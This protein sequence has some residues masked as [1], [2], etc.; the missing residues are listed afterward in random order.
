MHAQK[1]D[2]KQKD[3]TTGLEVSNV[4]RSIDWYRPGEARTVD[5]GG[6]RIT[7]VLVERRG[8]RARIAITAPAGALF[9]ASDCSSAVRER[10][11]SRR[12]KQS[13]Y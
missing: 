10:Q 9:R 3:D 7:V 5:I 12:T 13:S 8:R 1:T 6:H 2:R 11:T 4:R